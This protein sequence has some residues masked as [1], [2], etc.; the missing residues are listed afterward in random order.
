MRQ[1]AHESLR[2]GIQENKLILLPLLPKTRRSCRGA[3]GT[4]NEDGRWKV[5][6]NEERRPGSRPGVNRGE[7]KERAR[8]TGMG[9]GKLP[10]ILSTGDRYSTFAYDPI[11]GHLL[12]CVRARLRRSGWMV[13]EREQ[14]QRKVADAEGRDSRR[15]AA[16]V[17]KRRRQ[18]RGRDVHGHVI[19]RYTGPLQILFDTDT[20]IFGSKDIRSPVPP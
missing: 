16:M 8:K 12:V 9:E 15:V 19:N 20:H 1:G 18:R 14:K 17:A 3:G 2:E 6:C 5:I 11:Q 10:L 4:R 7:S 13:S